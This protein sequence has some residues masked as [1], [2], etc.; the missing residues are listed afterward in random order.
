M[1]PYRIAVAAASALLVTALAA[2]ASASTPSVHRFG[3]VHLGGHV[4]FVHG[5]NVDGGNWSGY[6]VHASGFHAVVANWVEPHVT[7]NSNRDLFAPWVGID[8]YG[9]STV[10]Q[11]GVATDCSSGHPEYAGWY[12]MYP[13]APV[14]YANA[15]AAGDHFTARVSRNASTYTLTLTN[16]TKGWTK[17]T[18]KSLSTARNVSAEV[19]MESPTAAYPDF[20]RVNFTGARVDG[21]TLAS[22]QPTALDASNSHGFEDHTSAITNGTRFHIDYLRE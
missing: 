6:A 15:V 16:H 17:R 22:V 3:P 19:I 2:P 9:S 5:K 12:E 21:A 4:G 8:G 13:A 11:T 1:R 10:E 18:T 20:G 7:C 14:Y